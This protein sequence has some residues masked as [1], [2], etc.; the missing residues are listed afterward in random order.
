MS[1]KINTTNYQIINQTSIN[2]TNNLSSLHKIENDLSQS[3][4]N[5]NSYNKNK[6]VQDKFN[7]NFFNHKFK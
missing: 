1:S 3:I 5:K 4:E 2:T 6:Q 7:C